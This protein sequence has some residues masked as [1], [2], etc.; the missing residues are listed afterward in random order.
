MILKIET[1]APF[2]QIIA[3][4]YLLFVYDVYFLKNPLRQ[5]Y[6]N[7]SNKLSSFIN[8]YQ[9]TPEE[10]VKQ[11]EKFIGEQKESWELF[12]STFKRISLLYFLFCLFLLFYVGIENEDKN[13]LIFVVV[14]IFLYSILLWLLTR[15]N[16]TFFKRFLGVTLFFLFLIILF[17][18]SEFGFIKFLFFPLFGNYAAWVCV[19]GCFFGFIIWV[20]QIIIF[21][22]RNMYINYR[23]RKLDAA[24]TELIG[25]MANHTSNL[26][27][28]HKK[29]L[30]TLLVNNNLDTSKINGFIEKR[31]STEFD[32]F[33]K[34]RS[35]RFS[36]SKVCRFLVFIRGGRG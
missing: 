19:I 34:N 15:N 25:F 32:R 4:V 21:Y 10:H 30:A 33:F 3:G 14:G 13:S 24:F 29:A 28:K 27:R 9:G 6:E 5:R 17:C 7:V 23:L 35:L 11:A 8:R 18:I 26:S 22:F 31:I 36:S 12:A 20:I 16:N 2:I 1:F